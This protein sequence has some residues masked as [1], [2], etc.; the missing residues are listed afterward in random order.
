LEVIARSW[1]SLTIGT[2]M[3]ST[4]IV[5]EVFEPFMDCLTPEVARKIVALRAKPEVQKRL[6]ELG[7]RANEG[8]LSSD[9][10]AEYER[11]LS[12]YRMITI[13]QSKARQYLKAHQ[14]S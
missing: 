6:D 7:D 9:E 11:F 10:R 5:D 13:L 1:T 3:S 12:L 8:T 14:L 4:E 2:P